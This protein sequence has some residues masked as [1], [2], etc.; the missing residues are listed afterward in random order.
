MNDAQQNV[1]RWAARGDRIAIATVVDAMGSAPGPLGTEMAI[2]DGGEISGSVSGG[3]AEGAVVADLVG[4]ER[5]G[6][7]TLLVPADP[8]VIIDGF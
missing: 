3:C 1:R 8:M 6:L 4:S 5:M 2:N 7:G